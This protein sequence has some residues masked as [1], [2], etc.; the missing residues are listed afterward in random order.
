MII[1]SRILASLKLATGMKNNITLPIVAF[2]LALSWPRVGQAQETIY[3]SSLGLPSTG[4]A[5]VGNNSW[6]ATDIYTGPNAGGY[7]LNSV[8][9]ALGDAIGNPSGFTAMIY[10]ATNII[11][12]VVPGGSLATLD[13]SLDPVA[14]GIY[15]YTPVSSLLL[16][17][18]T[19]YFIVLTAGTP[20]ANGA[21]EWSVTSTYAPTVSGGWNGD[22][23]RFS[24]SDGLEWEPG[25]SGYLQFAIS[26]TA[27]P[28]PA[29][30]ALLALGGF[31]LVRHRRKSH[32]G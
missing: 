28:E 21:Y 26:A 22:H 29:S 6:L 16:S 30:V 5:A 18:T 32:G 4:S 9:L 2:A 25:P 1:S 11:I 27:I 10:T 24:S 19:E 17:P 15:T 7:L 31:F 14:G 3:I 13:G 8:H 23:I 20:V 12:A